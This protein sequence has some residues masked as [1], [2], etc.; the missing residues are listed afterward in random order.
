MSKATIGSISH[1]TLRTVDLLE[2]FADELARLGSPV[3]PPEAWEDMDEDTRAEWLE[4]L[5][6]ELQSHAP[7]FTY[8]GA[9]PGDGSDF[10]FWP[11]IEAIEELP[12]VS[13]PSEVDGMG[14]E[15]AFVNDHGNITVYDAS[16]EV[17]FDCV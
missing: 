7:N 9:H 1:G 10:G 14:V 11:D 2:S 4:S 13:D 5:F 8:F 17:I 15:C 6:D 3:E 16:G 12:R